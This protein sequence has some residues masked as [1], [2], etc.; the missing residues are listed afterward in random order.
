MLTA[1]FYG[2]RGSCACSG[3]EYARFGGNTSCVVLERPGKSPILLDAGSGAR[4]YGQTL[5]MSVACDATILL[6]HL[7]Y[8]HVLGLPF[9]AP[10]TSDGSKLE[11]YGPVQ[12]V[13]T[14]AEAMHQLIQPPYFPVGLTD[15]AAKLNF[16]D[17]DNTTF[18]VE[19]AKIT[20]RSVPHVGPTVGYR[21]ETDDVSIA[22]VS[23]HQQPLD[24]SGSVAKS[25]LELCRDVDVLI[26][27]AQFTTDEFVTRSTW[28]HCTVD[29][30]VDVAIASGAKQ[31][32]LY[33]HD[34]LHTDEMLDEIVVKARDRAS[35]G[36]LDNVVCASDG[37]QLSW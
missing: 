31:L 5:D 1:T 29:Y 26:H 33:H 32:V 30:T 17:V 16:S 15:F 35:D 37:M 7:H 12:A 4:V 34:P 23:D 21:I 9:F 10:A 24:G 14:L 11:V 3:P 19:G 2:T 25:V 27:D 22:Y 8:D 18:M 28:G 6:T 36:G 20:V 13:G